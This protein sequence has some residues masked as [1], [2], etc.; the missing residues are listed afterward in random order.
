MD[1]TIYTNR[2]FGQ[3]YYYVG[4]PVW[5]TCVT[6]TV[7]VGHGVMTKKEAV[8]TVEWAKTLTSEMIESLK[9][10]TETLNRFDMPSEYFAGAQFFSTPPVKYDGDPAERQ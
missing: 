1:W 7:H 8:I 2:Q 5:Q 3:V 4:L 6:E 10:T 9:A